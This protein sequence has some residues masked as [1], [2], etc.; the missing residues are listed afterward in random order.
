MIFFGL[1]KE[2]QEQSGSFSSYWWLVKLR[3]IMERYYQKAK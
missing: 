3:K 2:E 1:K